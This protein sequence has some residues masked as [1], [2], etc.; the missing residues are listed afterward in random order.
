MNDEKTTPTITAKVISA[1]TPRKTA[2][3]IMASFRKAAEDLNAVAI[4]EDNA[5]KATEDQV[6]TLIQ[7][8]RDLRDEAKLAR[9]YEANLRAMFAE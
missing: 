2:R 8:A 9:Q 4:R 3:G 6:A 7:Q 1:V 5:A